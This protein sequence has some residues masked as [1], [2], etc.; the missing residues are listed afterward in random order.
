MLKLVDDASDGLFNIDMMLSCLI[1]IGR[2]V[3]VSVN[4]VDFFGAFCV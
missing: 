2:H 1:K 4:V 3:R